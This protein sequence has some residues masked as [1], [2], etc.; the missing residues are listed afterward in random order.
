MTLTHPIFGPLVGQPTVEAAVLETLE[1]WLPYM[2][3]VLERRLS[4]PPKTLTAPPGHTSYFGGLD[5]E[6]WVDEDLPTVIAVVNPTGQADRTTEGYSQFFE[7]EVGVIVNTESEDESRALAGHIG[8]AV[9]VAL[10][11]HGDLGGIASFT[12]LVSAAVLEFP[13]A[14]QRTLVRARIAFAAYVTG[15]VND[16]AGPRT[17][18]PPDSPLYPDDPDAPFGD[19]PAHTETNVTVTRA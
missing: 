6:S 14:D 7:I 2:L 19:W 13:E 10:P 8:T 17:A 11:Q 9:A 16:L 4:L 15:L 18:T 5:F 12:R 3:R 1:A